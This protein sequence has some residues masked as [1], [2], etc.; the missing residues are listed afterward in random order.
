MTD[1]MSAVV[2]PGYWAQIVEDASGRK[3]DVVGKP[4]PMMI[5]EFLKDAHQLDLARS[6]FVG[7]S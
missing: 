2:G 3:A 5:T 6:A 4:A 1:L 7:D